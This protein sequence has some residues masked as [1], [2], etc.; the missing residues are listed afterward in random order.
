LSGIETAKEVEKEKAAEDAKKGKSLEGEKKLTKEELLTPSR[1]KNSA[2][3]A[4]PCYV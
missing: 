3:Y 4:L 1:D 2:K